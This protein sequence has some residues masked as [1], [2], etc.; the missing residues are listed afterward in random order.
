MIRLLRR[1]VPVNHLQ[2]ASSLLARSDG[3]SSFVSHHRRPRLLPLL[4]MLYLTADDFPICACP[5]TTPSAII[6]NPLYYPRSYTLRGHW[7]S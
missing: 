5:V 2:S 7:V 4:S 1:A 3:F 6:I